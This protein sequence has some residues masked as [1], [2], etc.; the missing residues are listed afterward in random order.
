MTSPSR[1][2]WFENPWLLGGAVGLGYTVPMRLAFAALSPDAARGFAGVMSLAFLAV[3]PA[4]TGAL[5]IHLAGRRGPVSLAQAITVPWFACITAIAAA[6]LAVL[7]GTICIVLASP[8]FFA[9]GSAGGLVMRAVLRRRA[10]RDSVVAAVALLPLLLGGL[11]A[12]VPAPRAVVRVENVRE[13]D[14]PAEVVWRH[15]ATVPALAPE[16]LPWSFAHAIGLPRPIEATL[17]VPAVGGVRR[18]IFDRGLV[19]REEVTDWQPGRTI[20]FSIA[21][22][23]APAEALDEHVVVGGRYF[24]VLEG[25]YQLEPLPGGRTRVVLS[26]THRLSTTLNAYAG[27]WSRAIMWDLQ[28]VIMDAIARRAEADA[29]G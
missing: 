4:A 28:R 12:R 8:L 10:K 23:Q 24:D 26:S 16:E 9:M 6:M 13:V 11:E 14:A 27:F 17:D 20:A 1:P 29:R 18:A 15:V 2:R 25:R 22:E 5:T 7:E 21:P 19:F 3:V